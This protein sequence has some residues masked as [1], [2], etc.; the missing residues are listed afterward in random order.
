MYAG[1]VDR[2]RIAGGRIDLA[3][4]ACQERTRKGEAK[5][6]IG[7]GDE[8]DGILSFHEGSPSVGVTTLEI[9]AS[10]PRQSED[11]SPVAKFC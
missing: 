9:G 8:G 3:C 11:F 5:P 4:A 6:A 1:K 2:R 7:P 10:T